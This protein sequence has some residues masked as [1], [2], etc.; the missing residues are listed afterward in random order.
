MFRAIFA[1]FKALGIFGVIAYIALWVALVVG[2][3][4]N[5]FDLVKAAIGPGAHLT[6][7]IALR[8]LG[9]FVLPLGGVL[10]WF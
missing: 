3:I 1:F 9:I 2:W 4:F 6:L 7:L 8:V 10:G 5:I